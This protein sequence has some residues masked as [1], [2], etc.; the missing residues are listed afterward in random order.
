MSNS[1]FI[2][3]LEKLFKLSKLDYLPFSLLS[4]KTLLIKSTYLPIK[5]LLSA[6]SPAI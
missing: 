3:S 1:L 5:H 6:N 2:K 4:K